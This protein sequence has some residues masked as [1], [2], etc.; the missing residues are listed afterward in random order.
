M[1][2]EASPNYRERTALE[3]GRRPPTL[4]HQQLALPLVFAA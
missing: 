3:V 4:L 1:P 2:I